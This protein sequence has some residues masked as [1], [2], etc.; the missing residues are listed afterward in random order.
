MDALS[1]ELGEDM[2]L[3]QMDQASAHQTLV[4]SCPENLIPIFHHLIALNSIQSKDC[5]SLSKVS[6]RV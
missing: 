3:I 4:L 6:S 5:G 1:K 2:A